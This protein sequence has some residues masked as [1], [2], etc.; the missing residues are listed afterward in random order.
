M[1]RRGGKRRD[2]RPSTSSRSRATRSTTSEGKLR[3]FR[4]RTGGHEWEPL[5]RGLPQANR[6]DNVLREAVSVDA[7]SLAVSPSG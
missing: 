6:Y 7:L 4:S 3:V 5:G 1:A 2:P